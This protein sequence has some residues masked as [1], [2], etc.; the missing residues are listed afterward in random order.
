MV[1]ENKVERFVEIQGIPYLCI[2]KGEQPRLHSFDKGQTWDESMFKAYENAA[3]AETLV[4]ASDYE[5]LGQEDSPDE[6]E[7]QVFM[8]TLIEQISALK[9]GEFLRIIKNDGILMVNKEKTLLMSKANIFSE[10]E[11]IDD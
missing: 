2:S 3:N 10:M 9:D 8:I 4:N 5:D 11:L 7:S 6:E 1:E